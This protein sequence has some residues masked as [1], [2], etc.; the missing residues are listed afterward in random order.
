MML[1][2][3]ISRQTTCHCE[4][5]S[6]P[7]RDPGSKL[8]R[9]LRMLASPAMAGLVPAIRRDTVPLLMAGTRPAMTMRSR[10]SKVGLRIERACIA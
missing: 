1:A 2:C 4:E 10:F 7:G 5:R 9:A 3:R 6:G 8:G